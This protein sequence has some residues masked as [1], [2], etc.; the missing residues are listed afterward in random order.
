M[1]RSFAH[2]VALKPPSLKDE[3]NQPWG[4]SEGP[5]EAESGG[6]P[7]RECTLLRFGY[8]PRSAIAP[9]SRKHHIRL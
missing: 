7:G 6:K 9:T 3:S 1:R 8:A 5:I 4:H 2:Q